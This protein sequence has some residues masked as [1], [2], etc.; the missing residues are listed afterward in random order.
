MT[1]RSSDNP[2]TAV[3][4]A[5]LAGGPAPGRGRDKAVLPWGRSTLLQHVHDLVAPLAAEVLLVT[6]P[7]QVKPRQDTVPDSCKVVGDW[8][9]HRGPLVGIHTALSEAAHDRVLVVSCAMPWLN[10]RLL[11]D[12]I[13]E[14]EGDVVI[15]RTEQ[16]WEP[17]H[18]V[19]SRSC[20]PAIT[21]A[22]RQGQAPVASFFPEV[23]VQAWTPMRWGAYDP[24]GRSF[25]RVSRL[26]ERRI[27]SE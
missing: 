24:E 20:L 9:P 8:L 10:A 19:Y 12:M 15:P 5:I 25:G 23:K 21:A 22:L 11:R 4:A 16:G 1:A 27:D 6:R 17:L 2:A 3:T 13:H 26:G 18:A 14:G 7:E